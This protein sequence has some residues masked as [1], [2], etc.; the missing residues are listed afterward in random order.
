MELLVARFIGGGT[1]S[2]DQLKK[3]IKVLGDMSNKR[4]EMIART[5]VVRAISSSQKQTLIE[6]GKKFWKLVTA[7][8][9]RVCRI[10]G[11]LEGQIVEIGKPFVTIKG[12]PIS[13]SPVHPYCRCG[14]VVVG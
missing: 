12:Q 5:E 3:G 6:N 9:E 14:Q 10:C 2:W 4:A 7:N 13:N 11:P 1:V 8:D